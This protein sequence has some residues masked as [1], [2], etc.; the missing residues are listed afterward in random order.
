M[1]IREVIVEN[2]TGSLAPAVARTL[3]STYVLPHLKNQDP[4]LQYRMGMALAAARHPENWETQSAFGENMS[5]VGYTD[6]DDE[7]LKL[8]LKL[9]GPEYAA[10]AKLIS[11]KKSE[12]ATDVNKTSPMQAQGPIRRRG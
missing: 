9:I 11:T 1:K 3:P 7:T 10:G 4:Y 5:V 6:A 12:E 8:A 2:G